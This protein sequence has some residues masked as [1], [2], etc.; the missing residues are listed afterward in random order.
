MSTTAT[1]YGMTPERLDAFG[2]EIEAI[3]KRVVDELGQDDVDYIRRV[4]KWQRGLAAGGRGLLFL[5]F[6]PPAWIAGTVALGF[7]KILDN[8]EIGHN[9]MHGQYDWTRDPALSAKGFDWDTA[10]PGEQWRHSHN[11]LHHTYTNILGKDR[12]IGYA[13]LRMS[14]DQRW[15]PAALGNPVYAALLALNF[16]LGVMLHDVEFERLRTGERSRWPRRGRS[17]GRV[18][19]RRASWPPRTTCSGR[20]SPVRC[21][22]RPWPRTSRRTSCATS[23]PSPSSSAGTSPDGAH[24][25]T[26]AECEGESK[27]HWYFRQLL[28]SANIE[29]GSFFH[30]MSGNL[31][32]QIEH[33]LF[34]DIPARRYRT[35]APDVRAACERYGLPYNTGSLT[36]QF[37]SVV[38][39]IA[40]LAF[41][42]R[43]TPR[44]PAPKAATELSLAA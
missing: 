18:C 7:A 35:I 41:P 2:A 17:V 11:F 4:I 19:A 37:G 44:H 23:G 26:E 42:D 10:S 43:R 22:C 27:G 25:F 36:K 32:H 29:G 33:H 16:D 6:L 31:S 15:T 40:R 3:R 24:V 8:M 5:G 12:D 28:G 14:E 30:L 9:I 1:T 20:C 21:S 13:I 39:K 34:P 38:R